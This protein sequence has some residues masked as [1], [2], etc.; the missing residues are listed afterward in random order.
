M[1][2]VGCSNSPLENQFDIIEIDFGTREDIEQGLIDKPEII[3]FDLPEGVLLGR[4][5]RLIIGAEKIVVLDKTQNSVFVFNGKGKM[6]VHLDKEGY[7]PGEYSDILDVDIYEEDNQ[8]EVIDHRRQLVLTYSLIN[9]DFLFQKA[10]EFYTVHSLRSSKSFRIFNNQGI[11]N[12]ALNGDNSQ[13]IYITDLNNKVIRKEFDFF[14]SPQN[15]NFSIPR[16]NMFR[17]SNRRDEINVVPL[18][19]TDIYGIVGSDV[20]KKYSFNFGRKTSFDLINEI[21]EVSNSEF[22]SRIYDERYV[23]S[24]TA[25][26][27]S[28][29]LI[30]FTV[31]LGAEQFQ[32]LIGKEKGGD[33]RIYKLSTNSFGVSIPPPIATLNNW[34]YSVIPN[35]NLNKI[36]D[37]IE[38]RHSTNYLAGFSFYNQLKAAKNL[39][40]GAPLLVKYK[41][42]N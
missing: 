32:V 17:H 4:I 5:D 23:H 11:P 14:W 15:Q 7:G 29:K 3:R 21:G 8:I 1:S 18:H 6:M 27:E 16:Y 10:Y 42:M 30:Y 28:D 39:D 24:F 12:G 38:K 33:H 9:G 40:N 41:F 31:Q 26:L 25:F 35:E 20:F 36:I 37:Q 22:M 19:T 2:I 13:M 34:Y